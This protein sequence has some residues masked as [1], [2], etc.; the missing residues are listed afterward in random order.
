MTKMDR[1]NRLMSVIFRS[2]NV[3]QNISYLVDRKTQNLISKNIELKDTGDEQCFIIGNGPS[4]NTVNLSEIA[5][6][7]TFTVNFF[8][9]GEESSQVCSNYHVMIDGAFYTRDNIDYL[10]ETYAKNKNTKFIF[11]VK[12]YDILCKY[13]LELDRAF[14]ISQKLVQYGNYVRVDMTRDMTASVN[15]VLAAIQCALYI[16]YKNIYL[17]GCDFNSYATLRPSHFY[18]ESET[19]RTVPMGVD[20]QW[21]AFA[22]FHHYALANFA[23]ENG[24]LILNAT[25]GSLIDAYERVDL[26]YLLNTLKGSQHFSG[27]SLS[28]TN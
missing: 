26:D 1:L 11:N 16:G 23:R 22:H 5:N 4:L 15:V 25:H 21:S 3:L 14:F 8:H 27:H 28:D 19:D 20:L 24:I 9:R 18:Q 13:G 7:D 2:Y 6:Y 17:I 10:I 12:G